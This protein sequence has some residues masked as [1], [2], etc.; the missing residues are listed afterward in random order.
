MVKLIILSIILTT[1]KKKFLLIYFKYKL[2]DLY[3]LIKVM[4]LTL[5]LSVF[6]NQDNFRP[7]GYELH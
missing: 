4:Q 1:T 2:L 5:Y 6:R 7:D 3:K